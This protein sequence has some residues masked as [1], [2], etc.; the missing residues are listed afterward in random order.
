MVLLAQFSGRAMYHA[1]K[2]RASRRPSISWDLVC[3]MPTA[4]G[5][6]IA[7]DALSS[8]SEGSFHTMPRGPPVQA[9]CCG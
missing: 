1:E 5:I 3:E 2:A 6:D 8:T 7:G 4:V 9:T